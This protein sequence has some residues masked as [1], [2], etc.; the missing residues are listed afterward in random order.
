MAH[1][2]SLGLARVSTA[3]TG[4]GTMT[5]GAAVSGFQTFAN[6]GAVDGG[7]Y[8]YAIKDGTASEL[9]YGT[10][11]ASGTTLSRTVLQSTNSDNPINLSGTAEVFST[12]SH[13]SFETA[14]NAQ[15]GTTYTVLVTDFGKLV[16]HSNGS[17]IAVTLPQATGLFNSGWYYY[18]RN[19]GAG[20]VTITPTTST[21]DGAATLVLASGASAI[22]FSDGTNYQTV[23]VPI[24][25]ETV[26]GLVERATDTEAAAGSDTTRYIT[27]AQLMESRVDV[28]SAT[29]TDIGA[30]ASN[31]VR[32]TGTTTITSLG[33]AAAGVWRDVTF[34]GA[35]TLTHNAT[36]LL[37]PGGANVTTA[38]NDRMRCRS[39]GS[40]N[41]IVLDYTRDSGVPLAGTVTLGS[42]VASTSGTAIDFTSL[43]ANL[44]RVTVLFN[45][46]STNGTSAVII[47]LGSGSFTSSGYL[48]SSSIIQ[49]S[50]ATV[51]STT[52]F[53]LY[54]GGNDVAA[55]TRSG[56]VILTHYS[57]N[58]W[59]AH[60]VVGLSDT[61]STTVLG[62]LIA[63]GG[64]L[65]RVRVTTVGGTDT[66]DAGGIN[67]AYEA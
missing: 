42:P 5:L 24:A 15:T 58:V 60:G 33:T 13:T 65:D 34:A 25:S 27:S 66:F 22:I 3:T 19:L 45:G 46:V 61:N 4:T 31:F 67:I 62:G 56:S 51:N 43:P 50:V 59:M 26:P 39:L 20:T 32:I 8:F 14:V 64:V 28:A 6:A 18:T 38:A 29:T 44:K 23:L 63:L 53:Q 52:G 11:T 21:I 49:A 55:A 57:G 48:S 36:S 35:L 9:G 7:V 54:F 10:Y 17:S 47:R 41:W 37:I 2:R 30:A 16:T 1:A 40:G 12:I